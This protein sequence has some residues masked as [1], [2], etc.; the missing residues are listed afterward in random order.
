MKYTEIHLIKFSLRLSSLR[1]SDTQPHW[2]SPPGWATGQSM[3]APVNGARYNFFG[4]KI[5]IFHNVSYTLCYFLYK[6]LQLYYEFT[7]YWLLLYFI[8][9]SAGCPASPIGKMYRSPSWNTSNSSLIIS[10]VVEICS[11]NILYRRRSTRTISSIRRTRTMQTSCV[12]NARWLH[13][14]VSSDGALA[15]IPLPLFHITSS[16]TSKS[17][18]N[19]LTHFKIFEDLSQYI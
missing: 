11:R 10:T 9:I 3:H 13:H 19:L 15:V 4:G 7:L 16:R 6:V 17:H 18:Y 8:G 2:L 5:A 1:P 12:W 14:F